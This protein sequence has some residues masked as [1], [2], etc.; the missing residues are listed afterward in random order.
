MFNQWKESDKKL[1]IKGLGF[2]V[3]GW[4]LFHNFCPGDA[5]SVC[6][7]GRRFEDSLSFIIR[8]I[9]IRLIPIPVYYRGTCIRRRH[10]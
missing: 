6:G 4:T 7:A 9:F 2:E 10:E 5:L 3:S 8:F 1:V